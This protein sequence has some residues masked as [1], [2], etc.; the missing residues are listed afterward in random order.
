MQSA[1]GPRL[2]NREIVDEAKRYLL[3]FPGVSDEILESH[4]AYPADKCPRTKNELF[5]RIIVH[6]QNRQQMPRSIGDIQKLTGALFDFDAAEVCRQYH[7]WEDIFD[8]VQMSCKPPGRM[9]RENPH[10]FWV[11]FCK[12]IL[13]AAIFVSRFDSI[14]HFNAYAEGFISDNPDVRLGLPL[15]LKEEIFG[16]QFALACDFVKENVS[17]F[18]VKTDVHIR[19]IFRGIGI[20]AAN[21]SDVQIFRDAVLFAD[22]VKWKPYAIDKLFWLVGS[23]NFYLNNIRVRT[24]KAAFIRQIASKGMPSG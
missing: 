8:F 3:A 9:V 13:S 7:R 6:G 10:N 12:T 4:L 15:V 14:G 22:S 17:P 19:D 1:F 5:K 16:Y 23:G 24:N 20:S 2:S 18:F 21:A 11:I